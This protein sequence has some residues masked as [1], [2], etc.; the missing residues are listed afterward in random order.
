LFT[1][2]EG[3]L[4]EFTGFRKADPHTAELFQKPMYQEGIPMELKFNKVL[5]CITG[6]RREEYY[7]RPLTVI[8]PCEPTQ[9]CV[10]GPR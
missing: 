5:A 3:S 7:K 9:L 8:I 6:W 2:Q 10:P 4:R 1:V